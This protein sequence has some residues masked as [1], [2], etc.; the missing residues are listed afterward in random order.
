MSYQKRVSLLIIL[1]SLIV[2]SAIYVGYYTL[3]PYFNIYTLKPI[4]ITSVA[5]L[6][7]HHL[8]AFRY[9]LYEKAW[10]YASVGEMLSIARA[11]TLSIFTVALVQLLSTGNVYV[12][13]LGITWMLHMLLIGG[14]RFYGECTGIVTLNHSWKKADTHCWC[15]LCRLYACPSANEEP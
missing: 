7:S 15:R 2:L 4:V 8:F 1:D 14:S 3:H 9:R 13:V 12:R 5:L 11:V 10:E 6:L